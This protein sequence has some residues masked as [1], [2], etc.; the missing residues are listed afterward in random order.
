M[1][2]QKLTKFLAVGSAA[3]AVAIGA[4]YETRGVISLSMIRRWF[5]RPRPK[6]PRMGLWPSAGDGS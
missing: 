3:T 6:R 4:V 5:L 1:F 2:S